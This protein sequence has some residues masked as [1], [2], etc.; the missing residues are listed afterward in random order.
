MNNIENLIKILDEQ[1]KDAQ[2]RHEFFMSVRDDNLATASWQDVEY[3][4]QQKRNIVA[5]KELHYV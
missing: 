4:K 5:Y 2:E 3:L 1:I